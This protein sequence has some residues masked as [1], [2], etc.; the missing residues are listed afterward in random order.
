M[1]V[2]VRLVRFSLCGTALQPA[3]P[4]TPT[5]L[6]ESEKVLTTVKEVAL[7]KS[8]SWYFLR[9]QC[10]AGKM[11]REQ[12]RGVQMHGQ[13]YGA[14]RGRLTERGKVRESK[15]RGYKNVRAKRSVRL[16][17]AITARKRKWKEEESGA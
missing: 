11:Q 10:D 5:G 17:H 1:E 8:L 15:R 6:G 4:H 9:G 13:A 3:R 7:V 14:E 16:H 12:W 2:G